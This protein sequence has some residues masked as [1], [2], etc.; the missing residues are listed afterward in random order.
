MNI[1]RHM[2]QP[3]LRRDSR[4]LASTHVLRIWT[5][6]DS[7]ISLGSLLIGGG[8]GGWKKQEGWKN[9]LEVINWGFDQAV[10]G[11]GL[12]QRWQQHVEWKFTV[13]PWEQAASS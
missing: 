3:S 6:A 2:T 10:V 1:D 7:C 5:H 11:K 12:K 4:G 8:M 13:F 9:T